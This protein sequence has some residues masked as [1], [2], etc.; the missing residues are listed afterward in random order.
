MDAVDRIIGGM[1]KKKKST[2]AEKASV[3]THEA[4][5]TAVQS[6]LLEYANPLVKVTIVPGGKTLEQRGICQKNDN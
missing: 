1:E 2:T 3:A 4:G 6:W 5:H